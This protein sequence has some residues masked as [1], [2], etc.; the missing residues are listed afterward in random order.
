MKVEIEVQQVKSIEIDVDNELAKDILERFRLWSREDRR[1]LRD[2]SVPERLQQ[3][4]NERYGNKYLVLDWAVEKEDLP[5]EL[6]AE[7]SDVFTG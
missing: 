5:N 2:N 1:E 7:Y 3:L 6:A 4:V